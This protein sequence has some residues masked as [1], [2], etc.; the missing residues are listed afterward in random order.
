[1]AD[2]GGLFEIAAAAI[3]DI[4]VTEGAKRKRWLRIVKIISW[5]IFAALVATLIFVTFKYST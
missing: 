1:M 4:F 2:D 5:V 3:V